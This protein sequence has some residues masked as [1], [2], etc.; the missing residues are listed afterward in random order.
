MVF[1]VQELMINLTFELVKES[2]AQSKIL[3]IY[4]SIT[5]TTELPMP[6]LE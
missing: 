5:K 1:N 3:A 6:V 2:Q 4:D